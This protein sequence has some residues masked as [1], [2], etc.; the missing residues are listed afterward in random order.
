MSKNKTTETSESVVDF[1]ATIINEGKRK[2]CLH[3]IQ[4]IKTQTNM[5]PKLWGTSIIG[6][7]SYH[8]KYESGREGDSP[9]VA[10]S[11]R[12]TS[13]AIYLCGSFKNREELLIKLGKHKTDKGCIHIKKLQEINVDIL[14]E[15]IYCHI[16]HI[17]SLYPDHKTS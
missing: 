4:T 15:M 6:F 16:K 9:L 5:N 8:Y 11:P 10:F 1:I 13:I 2:D 3:L 7:G 17:T 14:K 12:A